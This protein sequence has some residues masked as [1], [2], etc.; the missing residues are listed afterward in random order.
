MM[1]Q[2]HPM[3]AW[4]ISTQGSNLTFAV[5]CALAL[6]GVPVRW[7][8]ALTITPAPLSRLRQRRRINRA[9]NTEQGRNTHVS[10]LRTRPQMTPQRCTGGAQRMHTKH[11]PK[12]HLKNPLALPRP[13]R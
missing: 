5:L 9:L 7:V 11:P 12:F 13:H 1:W 6:Y 2:L 10:T 8:V 3:I 4:I